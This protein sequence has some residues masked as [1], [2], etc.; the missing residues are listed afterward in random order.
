MFS[1]VNDEIA[2]DIFTVLFDTGV[3]SITLFIVSMVLSLN[4][5]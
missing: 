1:K 3:S 2:Q 5:V 4:L